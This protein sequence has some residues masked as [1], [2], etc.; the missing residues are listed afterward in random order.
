MINGSLYPDKVKPVSG[1]ERPPAIYYGEL[2]L[3]ENAVPQNTFVDPTGWGKGIIFVNENNLGRYWPGA[4]P[5]VTLFIPG[6]YLRP[7]PE[8]NQIVVMETDS[9][10]EE[11][12]M[13]FTATNLNIELERCI[14]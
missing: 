2:I 5:Q 10:P 14:E 3:P 6:S 1:Q 7:A 12:S 13:R 11:M 8:I 9:T 4:G